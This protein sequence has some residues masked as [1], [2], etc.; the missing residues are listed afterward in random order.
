MNN[1]GD[2][3]KCAHVYH[4][5]LLKLRGNFKLHV[6]FNSELLVFNLEDIKY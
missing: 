4:I 2:Y 3:F 1:Y 5:Q 6:S